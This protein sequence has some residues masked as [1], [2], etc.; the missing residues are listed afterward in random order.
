[1]LLTDLAACLPL[2][3]DNITRNSE[4]FEGCVLGQ[5]LEWYRDI[6]RVFPVMSHGLLMTGSRYRGQDVSE[7]HPKPDVILLADVIYYKSVCP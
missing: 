7:V 3:N 2:I 4:V 6:R 5:I 1:M